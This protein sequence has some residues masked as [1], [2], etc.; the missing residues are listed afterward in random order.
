MV[1]NILAI[2]KF[3]IT[4]IEFQGV[5]LN[6]LLEPALRV[7]GCLY[8]RPDCEVLCLQ[9]KN[10]WIKKMHYANECI[11]VSLNM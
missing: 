1:E 4:S 9:Q 10:I 6:T 11:L 2:S 5:I 8:H 3:H 7:R